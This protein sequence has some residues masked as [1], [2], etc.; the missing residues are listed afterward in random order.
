MRSGSVDSSILA[1]TNS[2]S[3]ADTYF[4]P[5]TDPWL[6]QWSA[7]ISARSL[8]IVVSCTALSSRYMQY[9]SIVASGMN[10]TNGMINRALSLTTLPVSP[11]LTKHDV[12][13]IARTNIKINLRGEYGDCESEVICDDLLR[14]RLGRHLREVLLQHEGSLYGRADD[15]GGGYAHALAD[16]CHGG[17][18]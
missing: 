13:Q 16:V 9:K 2:L 7:M 12:I 3:A 4:V 6:I 1:G 18:E 11:L 10:A 17:E 14:A 15:V 8:L 5:G